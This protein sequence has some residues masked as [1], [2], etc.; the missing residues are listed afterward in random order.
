[1]YELLIVDDVAENLRMLQLIMQQPEYR[2]RAATS[3]QIA[4]KLVEKQKPDLIISDIKMPR[5]SGIELCKI[6]KENT[7]TSDIPVIFVS[8]FTDVESIVDALDSGGVDYISKPYRPQEVLARVKTQLAL[9]E[10][11]KKLLKKEL[12]SALNNLVVGVANEINTPLGTSILTSTHMK[13]TILSFEQQFR[14]QKITSAK[15][16]DFI[17]FCHD[18]VDL[19]LNNL[20]RVADMM[21]MFKSIS[22]TD[23][24]LDIEEI[25]LIK[26]IEKVIAHYHG[27]LAESGIMVKL[28]GDQ[29]TLKT[30]PKLLGI[31]FNNLIEN[32]LVHAYSGTDEKRNIHL[33]WQKTG[34][35]L[36]I[37][38]WDNGV[39][40]EQEA[41]S[42]VI[43]PFYTTKRGR[44]GHVGLSATVAANIINSSL[45]GSAKLLSDERGLVWQIQLPFEL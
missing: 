36:T 2:I 41:L 20:N 42:E 43:R 24:E 17:I 27:K 19:N 25:S 9:R 37:T 38:Y 32:S 16:K 7:D 30:D 8:A 39:G 21:E 34:Q 29:E 15:L 14:E 22:A 10:A 5:M 35:H 18:S 3:G 1:M 4:L 31:V 23:N 12:T 45:A 26:V 11:Q 28:D 33:A 13:E 6:L 40:V 44:A